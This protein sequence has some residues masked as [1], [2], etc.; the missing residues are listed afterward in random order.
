MPQPQPSAVIATTINEAADGLEARADADIIVYTGQI[1]LS[2]S[3][4]IQRLCRA[5]QHKKANDPQARPGAGQQG[6]L[7][8]RRR[9]EEVV[10]HLDDAGWPVR[11]AAA[12]T[13]DD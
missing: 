11:D 7:D 13:E 6:A 9:R 12:S 10:D 4:E 8:G 2:G 5:K 1:T 3:Q